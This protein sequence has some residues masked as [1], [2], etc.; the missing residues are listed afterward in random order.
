M[1][2]SANSDYRT[3]KGNVA[4][5]FH[6]SGT[7]DAYEQRIALKKKVESQYSPAKVVRDATRTYNCHAFVHANRHAW[8]HEITQ[9]LRDDDYIP[10]TPDL[11]RVGDV[12]VYAKNGE[13]THSGVITQLSNGRPTEVKSKWGAWPEVTHPPERVP[14]IYGSIVY[15]LKRR[16]P[17]A[18]EALSLFPPEL[19]YL[20]TGSPEILY[21]NPS[22]KVDGLIYSLL[23]DDHKAELLLASTNRVAE[24]IITN[25]PEIAQLQFYAEVAG[26]ALEAK[27]DAADIDALAIISVALRKIGYAKALPKLAARVSSLSNDPHFGLSELVLCGAFDAL[28]RESSSDYT[29][30][31]LESIAK[32]QALIAKP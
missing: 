26:S 9:F 14:G 8:F 18:M 17:D 27:I 24:L 13:L 21:F 4:P 10:V 19:R 31:R 6:W 22:E 15:Y 2:Y 7:D 30:F 3:L 16:D 28:L 1:P 29:Q 32:A 5:D 12:V 25:F 11:V 23:S 20:V